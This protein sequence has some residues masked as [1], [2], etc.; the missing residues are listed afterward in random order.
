MSDQ[1]PLLIYDGDCG[2]CKLWVARWKQLT[3]DKVDYAPYQEVASQFPQ[4]PEDDFRKSV[5]FIDADGKISKGAE[6][7]FRSLRYANKKWMLWC[8]ENIPGCAAISEWFYQIVARHRPFFFSITRF[9]WGENLGPSTYSVSSWIFLRALALIYL[10]AFLSLEVQVK[11]LIGSNGILP[12]KAFL[13]FAHQRLGTEAYTIVPTIFWFKSTDFFLQFVCWTGVGLSILLLIGFAQ[14]LMLFVLWM[15]YLSL[16]SVCRDFLSFQWD[17]LLLEIGFL[18]IFMSPLRI[19]SARFSQP[20]GL[21]VFLQRWLLFRLIFSSGIVKLLSA[22]PTWRNL[23]ALNYHYETQPLPTWIGWYSNHLPQSFQKASVVG[24]FVIELLLPF[25][26]F[27]PR[28]LRIFCFYGMVA[29][30]IL[31]L[32]TG[33][34]A[35]FNLLTISLCLFLLDDAFY[36]ARLREKIKIAKHHWPK[37]VVIPVFILLL[38]SS[39]VQMPITLR[40]DVIP[41]S[42]LGWFEYVEPFRTINRYGL[43]AV[44]TTSRPEIIVEGSDDQIDWKA[45]EFKYKPGDLKRKPS[46][47]EP[48]QPRLDWQMWFAALGNYQQNPWFISFCQRLLEGSP[49]VLSL[50]AKNPFPTK[51]PRYLRAMVYQYHFTDLKTKSQQGLWWKRDIE[52]T[53]CPV[54]WLQTQ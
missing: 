47:V 40:S 50:L 24:M 39:L 35:F 8:Y 4:I 52:G 14:P 7:V 11:G 26:I 23:T 1:K 12:A 42:M 34:Y 49:D 9:L 18:A 17:V 25:L 16:C 30:Q 13:D 46:F 29:L 48:H 51:P 15:L 44:M 33:N 27:T 41:Y 38:V 31:I 45:Y 43:F 20:T 3:A 32:L 5:Q 2:F 36:S 28:R 22:D 37:L 6:A 54:M 53:Y 10:V 19:I 21:I